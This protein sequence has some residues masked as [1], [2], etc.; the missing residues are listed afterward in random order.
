MAMESGV[1][2]LR[3]KQIAQKR[4]FGT[5]DH[6]DKWIGKRMEE[7]AQLVLKNYQKSIK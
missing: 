5:P 2:Y 4:E 6:S 3:R 7:Y 1:T